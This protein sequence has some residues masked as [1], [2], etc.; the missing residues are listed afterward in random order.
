[1]ETK[2]TFNLIRAEERLAVLVRHV[3]NGET[4]VGMDVDLRNAQGSV[5]A[6]RNSPRRQLRSL[7]LFNLQLLSTPLDLG[8]A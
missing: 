1:M 4:W 5:E 8:G 2:N 6:Y 7:S 3:A